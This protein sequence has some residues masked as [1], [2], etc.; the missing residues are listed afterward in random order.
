[1]DGTTAFKN[2]YDVVLA[3]VKDIGPYLICVGFKGATF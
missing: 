1:M 3:R 2:T